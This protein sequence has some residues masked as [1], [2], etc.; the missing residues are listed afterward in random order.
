MPMTNDNDDA[1]D[2]DVDDDDDDGSGSSGG[3]D[4]DGEDGHDDHE[5]T[6]TSKRPPPP[7]SILAQAWPATSSVLSFSIQL[8]VLLQVNMAK[9][10]TMATGKVSKAPTLESASGTAF[11]KSRLDKKGKSSLDFDFQYDYKL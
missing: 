1:N 2:D 4:D 6:M 10:K 3:D 8:V 5:T 7:I 11:V 9:K